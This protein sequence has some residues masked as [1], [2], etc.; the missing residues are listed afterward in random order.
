MELNQAQI[1]HWLGQFLWPFLRITGLMLTAPLLGSQMLPAMIKA[2]FAA[3]FALALAGWLPH[4]PPYPS[5]PFAAIGMGLTQIAF[6]AAMGMVM[7]LVVGAIASVGEIAGL[8]MSLSFA[9]L[10]L[11]GATGDTPVLYDIMSWAGL[12]GFMACGGVEWLFS[13][14]YHSFDQGVG[15][16]GPGAWGGYAQLGGLLISSAVALSLPVIAIAL[17]INLTVGLATVF[18]PQ[19]N[20]LSI[21]FPLLILGGLWVLTQSVFYIGHGLPGLMQSGMRAVGAL[22]HG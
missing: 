10:E 22:L 17:C 18:A 15:L 13:A 5:D 8:S 2:I 19:L 11:R 7:Q 21:G 3:A 14:L 9:E 1:L 6:G 20:L 12:I 4:L 16:P